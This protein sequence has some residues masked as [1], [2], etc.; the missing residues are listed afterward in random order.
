MQSFKLFSILYTIIWT[1][2]YF[3]VFHTH[4]EQYLLGL[5]VTGWQCITFWKNLMKQFEPFGETFI[6]S[7]ISCLDIK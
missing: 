6:S 2:M 4:W 5:I 7:P 1:S 3:S